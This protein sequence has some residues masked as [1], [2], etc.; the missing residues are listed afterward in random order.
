MVKEDQL[1]KVVTRA[2]TTHINI[3]YFIGKTQMKE[4]KKGFVGGFTSEVKE[5]LKK[6]EFHYLQV[7]ID[8]D[9][10]L[11]YAEDKEREV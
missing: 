5:A 6:M 7:F 9:L 1:V 4:R 8:R 3:E 10:F 2:D 11:K